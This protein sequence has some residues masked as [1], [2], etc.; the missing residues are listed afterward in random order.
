MNKEQLGEESK[1][2]NGIVRSASSLETFFSGDAD[3]DV[4]FL[5]HSYVICSIYVR[6]V[7]SVAFRSRYFKDK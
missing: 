7:F 5:D 2:C 4:S 3:T 1:L 6:F